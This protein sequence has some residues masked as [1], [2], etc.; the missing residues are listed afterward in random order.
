MT[1]NKESGQALVLAA[2]AL[3][4]LSGFAGLAIDMGVLRYDKRVQQAAADTAAIACAS[5]LAYGHSSALA[6]AAAAAVSN[7]FSDNT[8]ATGTPCGTSSPA[9]CITVTVNSP[10]TSGP[11]NGNA[12]AVEVY[13]SQ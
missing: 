13:V 1:R 8:G 6:A 5:D 4:V 12:N 3:T 7:G 2:L 9:G 10:P 11:H